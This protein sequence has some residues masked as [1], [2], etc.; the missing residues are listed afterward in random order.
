MRVYSN[1]TGEWIEKYSETEF[2]TVMNYNGTSLHPNYHYIINVSAIAR[3]NKEGPTNTLL[4]Q[5]KE[6]GK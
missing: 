2:S 1:E 3:N 4:I 5:T 6:E